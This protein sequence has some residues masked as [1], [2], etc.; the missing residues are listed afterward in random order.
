[1]EHSIKILNY[2][3]RFINETF[4]DRELAKQKIADMQRDY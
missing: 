4:V 1:M 3:K 2:E